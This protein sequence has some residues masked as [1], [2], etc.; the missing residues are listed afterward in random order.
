[1]NW[2]DIANDQEPLTVTAETVREYLLD[3]GQERM[4]RWLD[5]QIE[6]PRRLSRQ[7]KDAREANA[8]LR[9]RL[10]KY[11]PRQTESVARSY[12]AGPMSDG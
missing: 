8:A 2:R 11:E 5:D 1:M 12:R 4:A 3:R 7:L 6:M 10:E 9:E